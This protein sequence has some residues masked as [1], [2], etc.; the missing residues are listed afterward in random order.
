[1]S[2]SFSKLFFAY[3][4]TEVGSTAASSRRAWPAPEGLVQDS[5]VA[6]RMG[7]GAWVEKGK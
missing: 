3:E 2:S 4:F 1:M 6:L 5:R 7:M